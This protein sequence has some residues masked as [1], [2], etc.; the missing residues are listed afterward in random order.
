MF[1]NFPRP[2]TNLRNIL[3]FFIKPQFKNHKTTYK[4]QV[5]GILLNNANEIR[6]QMFIKKFNQIYYE[7]L[8][9]IILFICKKET[10]TITR[11]NQL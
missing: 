11:K 1:K 2:F 10:N 8:K 7:P 5:N 4:M 9:S 3:K 6:V